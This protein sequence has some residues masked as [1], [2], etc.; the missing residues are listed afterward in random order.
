MQPQRGTIVIRF[1][2]LR[3]AQDNFTRLGHKLTTRHHLRWNH[4]GLFLER[5]VKM[6]SKEPN[7]LAAVPS[8]KEDSNPLRTAL[9]TRPMSSKDDNSSLRARSPPPETSSQ[10][11]RSPSPLKSQQLERSPS[12]TDSRA[13]HPISPAPSANEAVPSDGTTDAPPLSS[14]SIAS[15][16]GQVC[17]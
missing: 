5:P 6:A 14:G 17:R 10:H 12:V 8:A 4:W 11:G 15:Q 7:H 1:R 13:S 3:I 2:E 16:S 9:P